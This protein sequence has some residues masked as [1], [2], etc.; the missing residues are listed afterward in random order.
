MVLNINITYDIKNMQDRNYKRLKQTKIVFTKVREALADLTH[1][2]YLTTWF[3]KN[4][5]TLIS[6]QKQFFL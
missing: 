3:R 1:H 6:T 4:N 2:Q 5:R